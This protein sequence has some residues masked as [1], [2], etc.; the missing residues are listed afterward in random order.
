M[1]TEGRGREDGLEKTVVDF[2]VNLGGYSI[3]L[4]FSMILKNY[5]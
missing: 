3:K 2:P 1:G 4:A 5:F